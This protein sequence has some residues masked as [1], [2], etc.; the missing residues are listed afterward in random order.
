[1]VTSAP[2]AQLLGRQREREVLDRLLEAA[3]DGHGGVLV[4]YGDPGVGKTALLESTVEAASGFHVTRAVGVEGEMELAF[5][6]LQQLCSPSLG[7]IEHLPVPQREALEVALGLSAGRPPNPFLVGLAVLSLLSEAAE[8][9]PLLCLVDDAQWLDRA[10]AS[11]LSFVARRLLA[12]KVAIVFAAREPIGALAGVAELRVQPLGHRDARALLES[13]LSARLDERVLERIVVETH[14]NPLA[15]LELPR[16]L[17]PAQLAGGFGVPA[18]LP[19][20]ARIEESFTRR[21]ARLPGDARRLL[22]LAA[23]EPLG[24]PA[25]LWRAA[26]LLGIPETTARV[27]EPEGLLALGGAVTFR[28]P[29]VRSAMYGAAAPDE[30]RDVHRAL[31]E[32]TDSEIYPDRRAW[33]RAQAAATPDEDVAAELERS[34]ERA[35]ARGGFAAAAA[36]L[37]RATE[38]TPEESRRSGR[39][40]VAAHTKLQAG[41]LDDALR[42]VAT[43]ESGVLSD[44]EQAKAGLL[45]AQISFAST[46][47]S[48][49]ALLLLEAAERLREVDPEL[50]RETYLEALEAAI[51]AGP[52]AGPGASSPEVAEA[53]KTAPP[54]RKPR[55]LD[56]LLDG[57]VALLTDTYAAAVPI[58]RETQRAFGEG[59]SQ[60]EQLRWMW[61][62]TAP[63]PRGSLRAVAGSRAVPPAMHR[64]TLCTRRPRRAPKAWART[65]PCRPRRADRSPVAVSER[66]ASTAGSASAAVRARSRFRACRPTPSPTARPAA[67]AKGSGPSP[68]SRGFVDAARPREVRSEHRAG[69]ACR[70]GSGGRRA[71]ARSGPFRAGRPKSQAPVACPPAPGHVWAQGRQT[72]PHPAAPQARPA[73]HSPFAP[74]AVEQRRLPRLA[75]GDEL[76]PRLGVAPQSGVVLVHI[77]EQGV[78]LGTPR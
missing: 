78:V 55:G 11:V 45:R 73:R 70:S 69:S 50:A 22:L 15:L 30:R 48:D 40:L 7:L 35:Q 12:E 25:L 38:L 67:P 18:A 27:V 61:G 9:Q 17:T 44:L 49:A 65:A 32:A 36:F 41:A 58:L 60:D 6:A 20:S 43:A 28:H 63:P 5:A 51:F 14:G 26:K 39:A 24:D 56:L 37:E 68:A 10:S 34:A 59:M 53:A 42:L 76:A 16:G 46:R 71:P 23:A 77:V 57:L 33:H 13:V 75:L 47:G 2:G 8:E 3:R 31:A 1:M 4:V 21:L 74:E 66:G 62:G 72:R 19:L 29:L 52:L 54:T 64:G